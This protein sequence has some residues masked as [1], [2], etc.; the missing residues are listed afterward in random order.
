MLVEKYILFEWNDI[1]VGFSLWKFLQSGVNFDFIHEN[2]YFYD[3]IGFLVIRDCVYN[4][5][6]ENLNVLYEKGS[7]QNFIE[8]VMENI[9][10]MNYWIYNNI[11]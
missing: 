7:C 11:K 3:S 1:N 5:Y 10:S 8:N 2:V 9:S 4:I 6:H